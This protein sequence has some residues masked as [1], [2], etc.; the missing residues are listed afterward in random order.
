MCAS[1][2]T[3]LLHETPP[4]ANENI[5]QC[6]Q[7]SSE[8]SENSQ[9]EPFIPEDKFT[10][11]ATQTDAAIE[12]QE[13][14]SQLKEKFNDLSTSNSVKTMILTIA[15]KSW[16]ENKLAE[17]FGTSRRQA[18]K[19]IQLVEQF[20]ILSSPNPRGGRNYHLRL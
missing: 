4:V 7:T 6:S 20:G 15:P 10:H 5:V 11:K 13:I 14:L 9:G 12:N 8:L 3:R 18:R 19:A 17:E 16:S 1:C 2:R